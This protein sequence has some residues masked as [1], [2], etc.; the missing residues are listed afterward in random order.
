MP[1]VREIAAPSYGIVRSFY[2]TEACR[3]ENKFATVTKATT[4]ESMNRRLRAQ[5][6]HVGEAVPGGLDLYFLPVVHR[7]PEFDTRLA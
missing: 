7:F 4:D 3:S 1:G 2:R 5:D 6:A